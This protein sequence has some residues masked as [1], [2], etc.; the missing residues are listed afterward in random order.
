[1]LPVPLVQFLHCCSFSLRGSVQGLEKAWS[2]QYQA[3]LPVSSPTVLALLALCSLG[4]NG[5]G[6]SSPLFPAA[7]TFCGFAPALPCPA[8]GTSPVTPGMEGWEQWL[9]YRGP[10]FLPSLESEQK[11]SFSEQS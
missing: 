6:K 11:A 10:L 9:I 5:V 4:F 8:N 7:P 2:A 1:V 3:F